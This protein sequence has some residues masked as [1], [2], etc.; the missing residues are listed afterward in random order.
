MPGEVAKAGLLGTRLSAL[1][2]YQKGACHMSYGGIEH[3]LDDVLDLK[4]SRGYLAKVVQKMS[5][6]LATGHEELRH[7][8]PRQP[9]LNIDG[10]GH[11]ENGKKLNVWGFHAPGPQGYTFFHIDPSKSADILKQ[12]L[13]ETFAGVVGCDY[14][15]EYR[16]FTAET[17]AV[18]Q[19]CWAHLIRD[20]KF[21]TTLP[22]PVTSRFGDKLLEKIKALFRLWHRRKTTPAERWQQEA[23]SAR[24]DILHTLRRAPLRAE[25]QNIARA[26][27]TTGRTTSLFSNG[28]A[29]RRP[30]TA[31]SSSSVSSSST[32]RSRK[33]RGANQDVVGANG[34]GPPWRPVP[35]A[36]ARAFAYLHQAIQAHFQR[37][38]GPSLLAVPP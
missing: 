28:R 19:F 10:T 29:C 1:I 25:V 15:G 2:A 32:A 31:S 21:L 6:A 38:A 11:P 14:A 20:V 34:F 8:L 18:L 16:R 23:A 12:F 17:D 13:G 9:M 22:D 26:S 5:A 37:R 7:A 4:L 24:Q 30:T 35:S 27:A 3:F 36:A 33:A